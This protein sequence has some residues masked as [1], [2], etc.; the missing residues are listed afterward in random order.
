MSLSLN[1]PPLLSLGLEGVAKPVE[2][3]LF[4]DSKRRGGKERGTGVITVETPS[5]IGDR[6][7]WKGGGE[8]RGGGGDPS[9][10]SVLDKSSIP[11][12]LPPRGMNT[13]ETKEQ[14]ARQSI[15]GIF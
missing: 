8:R 1:H 5:M 2:T 10:Q 11:I 13:R 7:G 3:L 12:S 15:S 6:R 9:S 4:N 14:A